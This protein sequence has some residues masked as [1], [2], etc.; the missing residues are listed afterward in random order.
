[1]NITFDL[2][3]LRPSTLKELL[4]DA[5]NMR[6]EAA[7]DEEMMRAA[8]LVVELKRAIRDS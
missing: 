5:R 8:V 7:D 3:W 4:F 1:M 6:D 2:G